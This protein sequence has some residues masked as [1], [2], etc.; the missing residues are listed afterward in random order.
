[1]ETEF[2]AVKVPEPQ[3]MLILKSWDGRINIY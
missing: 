2:N 3:N 1:M